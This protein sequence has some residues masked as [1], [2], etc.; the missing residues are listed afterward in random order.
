MYIIHLPAVSCVTWTSVADRFLGLVS[1]GTTGEDQLEGIC[2]VDG[3]T[4]DT[5]V[6]VCLNF[7]SV[8]AAGAKESI[9]GDFCRELVNVWDEEDELQAVDII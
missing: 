5:V 4:C 3:P 9:L 7:F 2:H 6:E 1:L 8:N